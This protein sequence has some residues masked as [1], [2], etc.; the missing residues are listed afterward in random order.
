M[1][2]NIK[3]AKSHTRKVEQFLT[4]KRYHVKSQLWLVLLCATIWQGI[5][6]EYYLGVDINV[7]MN[8]PHLIMHVYDTFCNYINSFPLFCF[9]Y[10]QFDKGI[11]K[12]TKKISRARI[13]SHTYTRLFFKQLNTEIVTFECLPD[14]DL[15]SLPWENPAEKLMVLMALSSVLATLQLVAREPTHRSSENS[16]RISP[17]TSA[18]KQHALQWIE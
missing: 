12:W 15:S 18:T 9:P 1:K 6:Y 5:K 13:H 2:W 10:H 14:P 11:G 3:K 7:K 16:F 4:V 8:T 17:C